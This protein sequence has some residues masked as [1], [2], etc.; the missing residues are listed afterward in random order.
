MST[1]QTASSARFAWRI[2]KAD[3]ITW[4]ISLTMWVA[5]FSLPL[6]AGLVLRAIL[7]QLPDGDGAPLGVLFAILLGFEVGRWIILFPAIVQW[8]GA[9]VFWHTVPRVNALRSLVSDPGPTTGRLPGSSGEAVSRFRDD[10]RDVAEVLDVWLDLI[11][12]GITT[13]AGVVV[14][15]LISPVAAT[16]IVAPILL[17][18]AIGHLLAA[19]LREW[20]W[21]ERE[22][23]A[24]V[25]AFIG[26]AFGAIATVKVAAAEPAILARFAR[27]GS[28]R[29]EAARSDQV[30]TQLAQTL[31][32]I[33]AN[34]GLGLALVLI[35]PAMSKGDLSIGDI[36][37]F[38]TYATA[39]S[40][41][42][43]VTARWSTF[44]R[45]G[46]VSAAR[47]GRLLPDHD[48]DQASAA[49]PTW[50]RGGPPPFPTLTPS[51][52][53]TR[54]GSERLAALRIRDL[55]VRLD[56][57]DQLD[58]VDLE[59]RRGQF[60]VITGPVGAGKSVLLRALLGLVPHQGGTIWWND[61][62]VVDPATFLVPPR[63]AYLPQ[64][65]RLFS[66]SLQDTVLLGHDPAGLQAALAR[67]RLVEDLDD[68][69]HGLDT[70]VGPKGV[71]LSG[72]QIQRTAAARAL[73]RAPELLVVDDLSSALDVATEAEIWDGLF[74]EDAAELTVLAV[75]HR[76]RVLERAHQVI[77]LRSGRRAV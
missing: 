33:T 67:A 2:L 21:A 34:A 38:T 11:A 30:G 48:P 31:G 19:R 35:A 75:S 46:D 66:E 43:R 14:L 4:G 62:E 51:S 56:D 15:Y 54:T 22:A 72:G 55:R 57:T 49:T 6:P 42:P 61:E 8:H 5:F 58:G 74:A 12:A 25:A 10:A 47:L 71:R 18:L 40:S 36:G 7:D 73:V 24:G 37:L 20:R 27:L 69:P 44:Q 23:T 68:M 76:P 45:Q 29:A 1:P 26:D 32:G 70:T 13:G 60:V 52:P 28:T 9:W 53:A 59:V 39:V 63:A 16:A 50:L 65:P 77:E 17:V 41:L 3:P 64:V